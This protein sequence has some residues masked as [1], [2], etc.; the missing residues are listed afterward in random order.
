M[1]LLRILAALAALGVSGA[2]LADTDCDEP[3]TAWKSREVLRKLVETDGWTVQRIKVDDG[4]YEVRGID[5]R[6]N[7]VKAK[8]GPATLRIRSL[9]IEFDSNADTSDYFLP[10][11]PTAGQHKLPGPPQQRK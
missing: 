2:A 6:G 3:F 4:C 8:Y 11:L 7:R 1:T 10:A 9:E 5:R